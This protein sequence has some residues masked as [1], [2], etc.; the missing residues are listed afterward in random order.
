MESR[1]RD[2][3]VQERTP[4]LNLSLLPFLLWWS[5]SFLSLLVWTTYCALHS[6]EA[7]RDRSKIAHLCR[8]I[9]EIVMSLYV[10]KVTTSTLQNLLC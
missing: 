7:I 2:M 4:K 1:L 10:G 6:R 9:L 3:K 5:S 8:S